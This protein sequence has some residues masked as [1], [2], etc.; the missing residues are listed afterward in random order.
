MQYLIACIKPEKMK[1]ESYDLLVK[2]GKPTGSADT[3]YLIGL[4]NNYNLF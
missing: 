2:I 3:A 1:S 4:S